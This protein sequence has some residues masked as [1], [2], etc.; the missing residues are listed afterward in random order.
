MG[1]ETPCVGICNLDARS[2][3]CIG[4]GRSLEQIAGW[5]RL[6]PERRREIM[7]EIESR[8]RRVAGEVR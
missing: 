2:G 5:A 7:D 4:C 6:A 8:R 1:I 3:L